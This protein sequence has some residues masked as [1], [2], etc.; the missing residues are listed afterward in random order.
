[1][2]I[3]PLSVKD[4]NKLLDEALKAMYTPVEEEKGWKVVIRGKWYRKKD[5]N[6]TY[7]SKNAA[8]D[9]T[10]LEFANYFK[11][12]LTQDHKDVYD[13]CLKA[14]RDARESGTVDEETGILYWYKLQTRSFRAWMNKL[15]EKGIVQYVEIKNE[16]ATTADTAK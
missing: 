13:A 5:G 12:Q 10:E 2:K 1:M 4:P 3:Q 6:R 15:Y 7:A 8:K 14:S 9:R 11:H 16:C